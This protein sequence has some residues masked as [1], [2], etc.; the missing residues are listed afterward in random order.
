MRLNGFVEK[1]W[2]SENIWASNDKY[3]G[4]MLNFN[5]G[6]KFSMH[7]HAE[8]DE[9]WYLIIGRFV[10]RVIGTRAEALQTAAASKAVCVGGR[11]GVHWPMPE[12]GRATPTAE[13]RWWW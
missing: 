5:A 1:G 2:G 10:V 8:K 12:S 11:G 4:K 7:F 3:C 13:T 9:T 6:A